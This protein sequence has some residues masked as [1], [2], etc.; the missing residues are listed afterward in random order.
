MCLPAA[1]T[2][3]TRDDVLDAPD[4][5]VPA[6]FTAGGGRGRLALSDG[7]AFALVH[8]GG[9]EFRFAGWSEQRT[10]Q[11]RG[12]QVVLRTRNGRAV[13]ELSISRKDH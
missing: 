7:R 13:R 2:D 4:D 8:L 6:H 10:L 12:G 9:G 5:S 3:F 11:I 1:F